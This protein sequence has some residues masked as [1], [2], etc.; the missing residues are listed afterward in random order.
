MEVWIGFAVIVVAL[1][2][3]VF[4]VTRK[5]WGSWSRL[6]NE[7]DDPQPTEEAPRRPSEGR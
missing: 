4:A 7:F 1:V 6:D 2:A 3:V 5:R